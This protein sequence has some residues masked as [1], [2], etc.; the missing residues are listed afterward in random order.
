M[1][2]P[3][4]E[5]TK[6]RERILQI[7]C[8]VFAKRGF[9]NTTIRDICQQAHVNIAAIN[10]YFSSKENLYEAVCKYAC[11]ISTESSGSNP[12]FLASFAIS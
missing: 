5:S 6:T 8:E 11:G 1:D 12:L 3:E 10:Y 4:N 9:R 2:K 7:A